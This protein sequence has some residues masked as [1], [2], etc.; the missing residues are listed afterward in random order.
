MEKKSLTV[1]GLIFL[2]AVL[3]PIFA[4]SADVPIMTK[5]QL[6]AM[7]ENPDL[8]I[9]DVRLGSDYFSSDL[10]IKGAVRPEMWN[11]LS[12]V[13]LSYPKG[14][15]FVVY[16]A[17]SNEERSIVNV[18]EVLSYG[19]DGY[20]KLYVLKGGWEEWLKAGYPTEKK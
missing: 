19:R 9:L 15:I 13:V 12:Y 8:V 3:L 16:C 17:S 6:K 7:L 18:K 4:I 20:T 1:L 14:K 2:T 10:K 11:Y 5:E